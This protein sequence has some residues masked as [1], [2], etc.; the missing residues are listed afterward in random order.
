MVGIIVAMEEA[1]MEVKRQVSR[2]GDARVRSECDQIGTRLR[3]EVNQMID[4]RRE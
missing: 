2:H 4:D 1:I 3:R